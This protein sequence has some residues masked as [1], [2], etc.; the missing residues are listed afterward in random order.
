MPTARKTEGMEQREPRR[1]GWTNSATK[2]LAE[3]YA[4]Q[5]PRAERILDGRIQTRVGARGRERYPARRIGQQRRIVRRRPS[6]SPRS[7]PRK[8]AGPAV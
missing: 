7:P 1:D 6:Q 3:E 2:I 4:S 8:E 5:D